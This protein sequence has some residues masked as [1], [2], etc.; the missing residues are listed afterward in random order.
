MRFR[1]FSN[2]APTPLALEAKKYAKFFETTPC[3]MRKYF[4]F[5]NSCYFCER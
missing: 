4:I 5:E 2:P 1:N 3:A